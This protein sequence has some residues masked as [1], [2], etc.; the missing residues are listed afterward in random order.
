MFLHLG[1]HCFTQRPRAKMKKTI[2][3]LVLALTLAVLV[4]TPALAY[5]Y[6]ASI[7]VTELGVSSYTQLPLTAA[8]NNQYLANNGY[9]L[10]TGLDTDVLEGA[11]ALPHL[12]ASDRLLFCADIVASQ[13]ADF[14][15]TLGNT[16]PESDMPVVVGYD[17]YV[18]ITDDNS[19]ELENV[20][21][22][23]QK[24]YIDTSAGTA[25][26][27]KHLVYKPYAFRLWVSDTQ[28]ISAEIIGD[29]FTKLA[30]PANL[31]TANAHGVGCSSDGVYWAVAYHAAPFLIIYKRSGDTFTK[32]ADPAIPPTGLGY[33][34]AFSSDG[35]YLAVAHDVAPWVS[36]YKNIADVYTKLAN[37]AITP[38]GTGWGVAFST[39]DTYLAVAHLIAPF[40]TI[41]KRSA[42]TFTKLANPAITPTGSGHGASF[43][44][45]GTYLA[46]AHDIAPWVSVYKNIADV[47]TKLADPAVTP[48]GTGNG[49]SFSANDVHLAVAHAVAPFVTIYK[50][51]ADT[52]TKLADPAVTPTGIGNGASFST[53]G[54]YL[55]VAH[56][57]NP[58]VTIYVR[59]G[60]TFT[61]LANP[62]ALPPATGLG[63]SFSPDSRYLAIA[64]A[65]APWVTIYKG[66]AAR[67]TAA[68]VVSGVHTVRVTS[69]G[70]DLKIF[71][72]DGDVAP[73]EVASTTHG[74]WISPTGHTPGSGWVTENLAYDGNPA[75]AATYT[76][77]AAQTAFLELT[78]AAV[79]IECIRYMVSVTTPTAPTS[80]DVDAFWGGV[81]NDVYA[82]AFVPSV[83]ETKAIPGGTQ[84]V[85]NV[86]TMILNNQV[87]SVASLYE[88]YWGQY[89]V[90]VSDTTDD[91]QIMRQNV[92]PYM[93]YMTI[94]KGNDGTNDLYYQPVTIV[95]GTVLPDRAGANDGAIT[96][97]A[98]PTGI[99]VTMSGLESTGVTVAVSEEPA[100]PIV[101][102][103]TTTENLFTE[104]T[105]VNIPLLYPMYKIVSDITGWPIQV[106]WITSA[107]VMA[108]VVGALAM[109]FLRSML[110]AGLAS[111]F[112]VA[113]SCSMGILPWWVLYV[114]AIGAVTFV[115]YQR[116]VSV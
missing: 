44:T 57:V 13:Q 88:M 64:H 75:T 77:P 105:G 20:F 52:F 65:F 97:G 15:Y 32:L 12:V 11:V 53:Y 3:A 47:F 72:G 4:V 46:V 76:I 9:M 28:E 19:I 113:V 95:V 29:T 98:N 23:E 33:G 17:G 86:R 110:I 58:F 71:I 62:A 104:T 68:P 26:T 55:A 31:P 24:G 111:G 67:V 63:A 74:V 90:A 39:D 45:S 83:F 38:T 60:D 84:N 70:V 16:P 101:L 79:S 94:D 112:V 7:A 69:D 102:P 82:G 73:T 30:N 36:I 114:Y 99:V 2:R 92:L 78:H 103:E 14:N 34:V 50:R 108:I 115:V 91:W 25:G 61:K 10:G 27:D 5:T 18:T 116:V 37:P 93:D 59:D 40:V 8:I 66:G 81:W 22:I 42:D 54:P 100:P 6:S 43:S 106:F 96:W 49:V 107:L 85:N 87:N 109:M 51:A 56:A 35:T 89:G 1:T 80:I 21:E 41:Y 48:T